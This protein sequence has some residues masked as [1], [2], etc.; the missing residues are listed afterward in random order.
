MNLFLKKIILFFSPFL[1]LFPLYIYLD[2]FKVISRYDSYYPDSGISKIDVGKDFVS[3]ETFKKNNPLNHYSSFIFGSSRSFFYRINTWSDYINTPQSKCYHFDGFKESLYG[4]TN[5]IQYLNES[6]VPIKNAL[7]VL[8][9]EVFQGKNKVDDYLRL[10][11]PSISDE[12]WVRFHYIHFK[13]YFNYTFLKKY[14]T[15]YFLYRYKEPDKDQLDSVKVVAYNKTSNELIWK[16]LDDFIQAHKEDYYRSRVKIF[17][18]RSVTTHYSNKIIERRHI[19][20]LN[21]IKQTF[22]RNQTNFKIII[23]PLYDQVKFNPSDLKVLQNLFG[24]ENVFDF[25]GINSFTTPV[26]NY[27]EESHYRPQVADSIMKT[28]YSTRQ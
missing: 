13:Q 17:Y 24:K 11:H 14:F 2:P 1:A 3:Y 16:G 5:K 7:V 23:S 4:I 28:I 20:Q 12:N 21:K 15:D 26:T 25:S 18:D 22:E 19:D 27:Y 8:D 10:Q 6:G 9:F